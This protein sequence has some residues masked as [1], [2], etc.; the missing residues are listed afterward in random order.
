MAP[1]PEINRKRFSLTG[2]RKSK[3]PPFRHNRKGGFVRTPLY[4]PSR[5]EV[6]C[7]VVV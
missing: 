7:F 4:F 2:R 1:F 5:S 3:K 6:L